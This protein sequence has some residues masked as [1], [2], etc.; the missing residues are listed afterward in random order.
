MQPTSTLCRAQEAL[1]RARAESAT[2]INVR[3][4]AESAVAAWVAEGLLAEKRE[5]RQAQAAL[6]RD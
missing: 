4:V 3:A 5:Q 2:L 6:R 1:H